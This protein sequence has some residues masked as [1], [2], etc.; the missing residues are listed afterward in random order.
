M[1]SEDGRKKRIFS[2]AMRYLSV[3][4]Q[5]KRMGRAVEDFHYS[6][7]DSD[8]ETFILSD[9]QF[10]IQRRHAHLTLN[11]I[12]THLTPDIWSF[13]SEVSKTSLTS[14]EE[15][16][17]LK[18]IQKEKTKKK[19]QKLSLTVD[20][21]ESDDSSIFTSTK[22]TTTKHRK[23][24][25]KEIIASSAHMQT[26]GRTFAP[27]FVSTKKQKKTVKTRDKINKMGENV[28]EILVER[29][30]SDISNVSVFSSHN[31]MAW[32][33]KLKE[34]NKQ[35]QI[36]KNYSNK[37][38][39]TPVSTSTKIRKKAIKEREK[40]NKL[41]K[42]LG[43]MF[44]KND[45]SDEN[46][47]TIFSSHRVTRSASQNAELNDTNTEQIKEQILKTNSDH[48]KSNPVLEFTEKNYDLEKES[49][50]HNKLYTET[51]NS[52]S[53]QSDDSI[54]HFCGSNSITSR[55]PV[56]ANTDG[57]PKH[58]STVHTLRSQENTHIEQKYS[59][60]S[61]SYSD[62]QMKS[63]DHEKHIIYRN[64]SEEYRSFKPPKIGFPNP[65]NEN[66]C[67]MNASLQI[68]LRM[69]FLVVDIIKCYSHA[70]NSILSAFL[71]L[72]KCYMSS[73][74]DLSISLRIFKH[75]LIEW[76][77]DYHT[78]RQQDAS[79]FVSQFLSFLLNNQEIGHNSQLLQNIKSDVEITVQKTF[80]CTSCKNVS[81]ELS[82]STNIFFI[83]MDQA[84]EGFSVQNGFDC[85]MNCQAAQ[86]T[87]NICDGKV[88]SVKACIKNPP[89][90]LIIQVVRPT[91]SSSS[92]RIQRDKLKLTTSLKLQS[93][94]ET[95]SSVGLKNYQ[96]TGII[97]HFGESPTAGHYV[98]DV[99]DEIE[100][101]WL[102]FDDLNVSH[103][104]AVSDE[105]GNSTVLVYTQCREEK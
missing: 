82:E 3:T 73:T 27:K 67:W 78:S 57:T 37:I 30:G 4:R 26:S 9:T 5:D 20:S 83:Y 104:N 36:S 69:K 105:S 87:C 51:Q 33:A 92:N 47:E 79:E 10:G 18:Q 55:K 81:Q 24:Y 100:E 22:G 63:V 11:T 66:Y 56:L 43:S 93:W 15:K 1:G 16:K 46:N 84:I 29:V 76:N 45:D 70:K 52:D 59:S 94:M 97:Y 12:W 61:F 6:E 41:E 17:T 71:N 64:L 35:E 101:T 7:E 60:E 40:E 77:A 58:M 86:H 25:L 14:T 72:I 31:T 54:F 48:Q 102:H 89:K 88:A 65:V 13:S 75:S 85:Q 95:H 74:K 39:F 42:E 32:K 53:D 38:I 98:A 96:L 44:Q 28:R 90:Y 62:M 2:D 50:E 21:S 8:N 23:I 99:F 103:K 68:I 49:I 80:I 91:M 34:N 19:R